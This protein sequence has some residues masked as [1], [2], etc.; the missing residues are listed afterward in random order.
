MGPERMGACRGSVSQA[1]WAV[2]QGH[3]KQRQAKL[4]GNEVRFTNACRP[5]QD[6]WLAVAP[7]NSAITVRTQSRMSNCL[8]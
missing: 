6:Q 1:C 8:G 2:K 3:R 7:D 5:V 4:T